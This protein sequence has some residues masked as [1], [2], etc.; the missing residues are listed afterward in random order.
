MGCILLFTFYLALLYVR[1][2]QREANRD[3]VDCEIESRF[4]FLTVTGFEVVI[5]L[6]V[7][8]GPWVLMLMH[9]FVYEHGL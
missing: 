7:L 1:V 9:S 2:Q 4:L 5:K 6:L 3:W 8:V